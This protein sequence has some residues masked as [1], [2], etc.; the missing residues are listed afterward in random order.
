MTTRP[1][2]VALTSVAKAS[3]QAALAPSV[4]NGSG[5]AAPAL[6]RTAVQW[7]QANGCSFRFDPQAT[8]RRSGAA[9]APLSSRRASPPAK[10]AA[11]ARGA[12]RSGGGGA[13]RSLGEEAGF[14]AADDDDDD[15]AVDGAGSSQGAG[16][17]GQG[18]PG[19]GHG[20]ADPGGRGQQGGKGH[21]DGGSGGRH[22]GS[23]DANDGVGS[24][25]LPM[26]P[27]SAVP[28]D[29]GFTANPAA[30]IS[31][32]D[33]GAMPML[34]ALSGADAS[35]SLRQRALAAMATPA[36]PMRSAGALAHV[37]AAL[38]EAVAAGVLVPKAEAGSPDQNCL[39]PLLLL[40]SLRPMP[41]SLQA[42]AGVRAAAML[43]MAA[44][45][46]GARPGLLGLP[47]SGSTP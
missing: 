20:G 31:D 30:S 18:E 25:P 38:I 8:P 41:A 37:R 13:A 32:H 14:D 3:G 34:Q 33:L 2:P 24:D 10:R 22:P 29:T 44:R 17:Q 46:R 47:G 12:R 26:W 16:S 40:R 21:A 39:L 15:H 4:R 6:N 9:P 27:G 36:T 23:N 1:P 7:G 35:R 45:S 42:H 11:A 5:N 19:G 43:S 28:F